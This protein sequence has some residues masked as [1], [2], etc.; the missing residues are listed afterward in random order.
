MWEVSDNVSESLGY[1]F[2]E[3][4]IESCQILH[5]GLDIE[6]KAKVVCTD[7]SAYFLKTSGNAKFTI[8]TFEFLRKMSDYVVSPLEIYRSKDQ[9]LILQ[10][11]WVEGKTLFEEV[12]NSVN[13][14]RYAEESAV[15]LK[16]FHSDSVGCHNVDIFDLEEEFLKADRII[17]ENNISIPHLEQ[18]RK[19]FKKYLDEGWCSNNRKKCVIHGDFKSENIILCKD[20]KMRF[21][22]VENVKYSDPWNEFMNLTMLMSDK[23]QEYSYAVMKRYFDKSIPK[24][25]LDY[26][27]IISILQLFK[28]SIWNHN[29]HNV[30]NTF[31]Q[32]NYLYQNFDFETQRAKTWIHNRLNIDFDNEYTLN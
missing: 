8:A 31:V 2:Q 6:D 7:G 26:I 23:R 15:L 14:I 16:C 30:K 20:G 4:T 13:L 17:C 11:P 22:D 25:F 18:W 19:Y 27:S 32:E 28:V 5:Q 24:Q 3:N 29:H 10:Y 12:K 9:K 21:V 1:F